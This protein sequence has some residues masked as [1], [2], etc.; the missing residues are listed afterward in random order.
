MGCEPK[1]YS[2]VSLT[3]ENGKLSKFKPQKKDPE[4]MQRVRDRK[5]D[6]IVSKQSR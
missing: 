4:W 1:G 2:R 6:G 5:V 3:R